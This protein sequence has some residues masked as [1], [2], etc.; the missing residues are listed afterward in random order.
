[1]TSLIQK[2]VVC[3]VLITF[4]INSSEADNKIPGSIKIN[5]TNLIQTGKTFCGLIK[6]KWI[7][8]GVKENIFTSYIDTKIALIKKK[9][10]LKGEKKRKIINEINKYQIKYKKELPLCRKA[11]V[12]T[13]TPIQVLPTYTA[14]FIPTT[15]PLL[16]LDNNLTS[17]PVT[18]DT[19]SFTR[20]E[21]PSSALPILVVPTETP[22][23]ISAV[24]TPL[25]PATPST[26]NPLQRKW[27][28]MVYMAA[29]NNLSHEGILDIDEMENGVD[30]NDQVQVVV[31]AEF[32]PSDLEQYNCSSNCFNRPNF[33][34]FRY[35]VINLDK[36]RGPDGET[37][38]IG[39]VNM[40]DPNELGGFIKWSKEKYPAEHYALVLWNHGGGFEG[41]LRDETSATGQTMSL[42]SLTK[43]LKIGEKIDLIDFDM[44]LMGAYETL[45]HLKGISDFV[46]FSE[47]NVPGDGNPYSDILKGVYANKDISAKDLA[48][49]IVN[50]FYDSYVGKKSSITRS[51]VSMKSFA[52]FESILSDVAKTFLGNISLL[53]KSIL[54]AASLT[55]SYDQ[56]NF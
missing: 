36:V 6:R 32:S 7:P 1:M 30:S 48:E 21:I 37:I 16:N 44:C 8:G 47:A 9:T 26:N 55:Q 19:L 2:L 31:Q 45:V 11:S 42:N 27:T 49:L 24:A 20:T 29:D 13:P 43:A 51:A 10:K 56:K 12:F 50:K 40:L 41:L 54:D 53:K 34:T 38:D 25:I 23:I 39:N 4:P 15:I 22:L 5:S 3:L 17:T 52:K 14:T 35:P 46:T 28:I 33:S 18:V